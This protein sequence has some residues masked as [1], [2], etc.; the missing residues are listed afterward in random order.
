MKRIGWLA[1]GVAALL[2]GL[3]GTQTG[4][5]S[6][7]LDLTTGLKTVPQGLPLDKYFQAGSSNNNK[8]NVVAGQNADSPNTQVVEL[9]TGGSQVGSIWSL[10][11]FKFNLNEKQV[12]SMWLNFGSK[13][14]DSSY[15]PQVVPGDGM[16]LVLQNAN[17]PMAATPNFGT[18]SPYGETLGVWGVANLGTTD[19][20]AVAGTAIQNSWALEFDSYLNQ[21][22]E[23]ANAK[24]AASFDADTTGGKLTAPHLA[25]NYPGQASTY[26]PVTKTEG[27]IDIFGHNVGGTTGTYIQMVHKGVIQGSNF[28]FL[29]DGAWH[30]LTLSYTPKSGSASAKMTYTFN[31]KNPT[32]GASQPGQTSSM[33]VDPSIIDPDNTGKATWGFTGA[34]GIYSEANMVAF[35]QIPNLVNATATAD[36]TANGKSVSDG[37]TIKANSPVALTYNA[38]YNS[39]TADWQGIQA[40]LKLPDHLTITKGTVSYANGDTTTLGAADLAAINQGN[41]VGLKDL[42]KAN[43]TAKISLT[44]TAASVTSSTAVPA[45]V[46]EFK[47]SNAIVQAT[48]PSFTIT[49][50]TLHLA[51][52]QTAISADGTTAVPVTGTVTDSASAVT[53]SNLTIHGTLN[54]AKLDDTALSSSDAAGKFSVSVPAD[55]LQP[56][57]NVLDLTAEDKTTGALSNIGEVIITVGELKFQS[58][59]GTAQ[60]QAQLTGTS[61]LV[62]RDS[63]SD[64][65]IVIQDT[66]ASGNNWQL[67]AAATPLTAADGDQLAGRLVYVNGTAQTTLGA[68]AVPVMT[69]TDGASTTTDVTGDW[70]ANQ[71]L[72][73]DLDGDAHQST[74]TYSSQITWA[75]INSVG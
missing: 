74:A 10:P 58:V 2:L 75:L 11:D 63:S 14:Y 43:S 65:N 29:S 67:T 12:A 56:G 33:D 32:T 48:S 6:D 3:S 38:S 41:G 35:E 27:G 69:H 23:L 62:A 28:K 66:R 7:Q 44:G 52:D 54:D 64:L 60:Y 34:T 73:L 8:A 70:A 4:Y 9:T 40:E 50:S 42:S 16:A 22:T 46:S 31:D 72:L 37:G 5:A 21:A 24:S 17:N 49:P 1:V 57:A 68:A 55:K 19:T 36:L 30:H 51:T 26:T 25:A 39:G 47:G 20:S 61:H 18:N 13:G 45:T 71:G 59:S 15:A 53:N